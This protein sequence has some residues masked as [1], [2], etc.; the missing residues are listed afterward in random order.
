MEPI[1]LVYD[2]YE[3]DVGFILSSE[4]GDHIHTK[5]EGIKDK[6]MSNLKLIKNQNYMKIKD[7]IVL[8]FIKN[9]EKKVF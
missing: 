7:E 2:K 3:N 1:K 9:L 8:N 4:Q 6:E 5:I